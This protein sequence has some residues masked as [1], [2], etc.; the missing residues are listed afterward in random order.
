M[1]ARA[2]TPMPR[3]R[4]LCRRLAAGLT[5]VAGVCLSGVAWAHPH[6]AAECRMALH[7]QV[8]RL[9][10]IDLRLRL[11]EAMSRILAE[12]LQLRAPQPDA[13]ALGARGLMAAHFRKTGWMT[14][15]RPGGDPVSEPLEL[16]AEGEAGWSLAEDGR[17]WMAV[18]LKTPAPEPVAASTGGWRGTIACVDPE[19]YWQGLFGEASAVQV[20]GAS[21]RLESASPP[22]APVAP[23]APSLS[24]AAPPTMLTDRPPAVVTP[25]VMRVECGG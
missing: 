13:T 11:D 14:A 8:D 5:G 25:A 19:W 20:Q 16:T 2:A 4:G 17:V 22:A 23:R 9:E 10:A 12:R 15:V 21:C 18:R 3:L 24:F 7:F 6:G 1:K